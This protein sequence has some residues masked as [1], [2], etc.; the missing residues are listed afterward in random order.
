M[1]KIFFLSFLITFSNY[2]LCAQFDI[3]NALSQWNKEVINQ[4][5]TA[6]NAAYLTEKEKNV[7]FYTNLVRLQPKLFWETIAKPF[8]IE[9]ERREKTKYVLSLENTLL[10]M[11]PV[12]VYQ[13][14]KE[15]SEAAKFHAEDMGKV[16][17]VG[18]SSSDGTSF[19]ARL[20]RFLK[21]KTAMAENCAYGSEDPLKTT[22]QLLIDEGVEGEGHRVSLL[23]ST[24]NSMGVSI[25]PHKTYNFN[26]VQDFARLDI[27][28]PNP[29]KSNPNKSKKKKK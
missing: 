25:K 16:G 1:K 2:F 27:N 20:E 21:Q 15:L 13:P 4:A 9:Y 22:M 11:K 17:K 5:N 7:I 24:Y 26:T 19:G 3:Q 12:K 10:N 23:S 28:T 14:N 29:N 6:K 8:I 18:H